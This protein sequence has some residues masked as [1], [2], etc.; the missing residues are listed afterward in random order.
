M[1]E[2][3]ESIQA[4]FLDFIKEAEKN[5]TKGNKAAGIRA[6]HFSMKLSR[7]MKIYRLESVKA[8]NRIPSKNEK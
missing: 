6:R 7:L 2:L 8:D 1:E 3:L 4:H 5:T